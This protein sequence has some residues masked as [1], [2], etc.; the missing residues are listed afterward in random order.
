M[1]SGSYYICLEGTH[2]LAIDLAA[3]SPQVLK[4]V[5]PSV[6]KQSLKLV[7]GVSGAVLLDG[8]IYSFSEKEKLC[9]DKFSGQSLLKAFHG[10]ESLLVESDLKNNVLEISVK[11]METCESWQNVKSTIEYPVHNG[12]PEVLAFNCRTNRQ[13][14]KVCS[15]VLTTEDDAL[16]YI[17][18]G[19]FLV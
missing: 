14:V 3:E 6:P 7:R 5:V 18:G 11:S 16:L 1:I 19:W 4:K 10:E 17:Q 2:L 8:S 12:V 9:G 13:N 15:F